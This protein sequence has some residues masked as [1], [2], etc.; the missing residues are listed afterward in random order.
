MSS[1]KL[2]Q[3]IHVGASKLGHGVVFAPSTRFRVNANHAPIPHVA[4]YYS[5][6]V[7]VSGTLLITE[8]TFIAPRAGGYSNAPGIWSEEQIEAW[9]RVSS[10]DSISVM[11]I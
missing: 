2:F 5:P 1:P 3:Q 7:K 8:A 9:K 4:E 6:T 11:I 10:C